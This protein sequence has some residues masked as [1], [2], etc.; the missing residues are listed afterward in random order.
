M[1]SEDAARPWLV[2][3]S[4]PYQLPGDDPEHEYDLFPA[5]DGSAGQRL[6]QVILGLSRPDY[7]RL[8]NRRNLLS[9]K[10]SVPRARQAATELFVNS[11]KAAFDAGWPTPALILLGAKVSAAFG[12]PFA[13]FT[14]ET[15]T[16]PVTGERRYVTLP[17]PSGLSRG[18][19][20]PDAYRRARA[21]VLPLVGRG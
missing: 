19:N 4:N 21:L 10:W 6:A 1:T 9:G 8:L 3:E 11:W 5:P 14:A 15:V 2:G 20:D 18:W 16:C 12:R 7:L 13:P 17:H